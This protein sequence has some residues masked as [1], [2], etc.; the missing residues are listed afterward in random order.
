MKIL[1]VSGTRADWG[2][3]RP[4]L[5]ALRHQSGMTVHLAMTGQH[6]TDEAAARALIGADGFAIDHVVDMQLGPDDGGQAT[7]EAMGRALSGFARVLGAERPDMVL[8]LGDRYEMLAVASAALVAR[9]PVAHIAGGDVTEGAFDDAIRHAITKISALHF[10]TNAEARD[11]V[12][13][14]GEAPERVFLTGSPGLDEIASIPRM[15]R[16][17]FLES[18][19]LPPGTQQIF[20]ATFHPATLSGDS[21]EQCLQLLRALDRFPQAS[22]IF[23]GSNADP[24]ARLVEQRIRSWV[25]A[26]PNAVFFASLGSQRYF[27]ALA[28][29]DL[30][31][32]NSSS[33]LYEAPSFAI[34]TVNI[35]DRQARRPRAASVIDCVAQ[36]DA[37]IG[38]IH[39]ALAAHFPDGVENP[40]GDGHA[41]QRIAGILGGIGDPSSLIRK[42]F[43]DLPI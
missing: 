38:A 1:A 13:Q 22:I 17:A 31:I 8:I 27:S 20:L 23:T 2:L 21:D 12:I 43:R 6:V 9:V 32:G 28:E 42:Q 24:G 40:Y 39:R 41:A 10:V 3:M 15:P 7:G 26:R 5:R 35:G 19:G 37:I 30:V 29:A 18:V 4:V 16:A 25:A 33:G 34:A 14:M 11:R 36:E